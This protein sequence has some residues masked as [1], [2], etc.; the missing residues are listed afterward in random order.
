MK[1]PNHVLAAV[2]Y[3]VHGWSVFPLC[4]P[5]HRGW[6]GPFHRDQ[7]SRPGATPVIPWA[8]YLHRQPK[9]AEVWQ[10][11]SWN[12]H[13]NIGL[14]LGRSSGLLAIEV[15]GPAEERALR[16]ISAGELP[17][18]VCFAT[19]GGCRRLLYCA[20]TGE[21][22]ESVDVATGAA[23]LRI[24]GERE[25]TA[26]PPSWHVSGPRFAWEKGCGPDDRAV[27]PAP[28]WLLAILRRGKDQE[29]IRK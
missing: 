14:A 13:Y 2:G 15:N 22:C 19:A 1:E 4:H 26:I 16:Q 12:D 23:P 20:T 9:P 10:W 18:T 24:R 8:D 25:Y 11:W 28:P 5:D 7:C 17:L 29:N 21:P 27:T 3:L 6:G